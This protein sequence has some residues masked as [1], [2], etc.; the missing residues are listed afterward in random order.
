MFV[1][2]GFDA[3]RL[4]GVCVCVCVCARA[5]ARARERGEWCEKSMLVSKPKKKYDMKYGASLDILVPY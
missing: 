1:L 3:F 5:H 2:N 4:S